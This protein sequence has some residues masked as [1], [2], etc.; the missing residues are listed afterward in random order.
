MVSRLGQHSSKVNQYSVRDSDV[1]KISRVN[2]EWCEKTVV[3]D[4]LWKYDV[5]V[6][7][8]VCEARLLFLKIT[9]GTSPRILKLIFPKGKRKKNLLKI[10]R[11]L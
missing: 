7:V 5:C 10:I 11:S 8:C 3:S 2:C 1:A 6:C 4:V 9:L